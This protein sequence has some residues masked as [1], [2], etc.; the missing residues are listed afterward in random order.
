MRITNACNNRC[1][2]CLDRDTLDGS[3]RAFEEIEADLETGLKNGAARAII[4][5]GEPTIH[6]LFPEI[7]AAASKMGYR[8][9]QAITNGRM[10]YYTDFARKSAQAGLREIT[11]SVH[12]HTP[13]LFERLTRVPGSFQQTLLG[14]RN[15]LSTPGLVV[16]ADIVVFGGINAPFLKDIVK[17]YYAI[18]VREFDLLYP[19]P[20]G[21]AWENREE[22]LSGP[23][24]AAS[25]VASVLPLAESHEIT[26]WTNRFPAGALEGHEKFIQSPEKIRDEMSGRSGMFSAFL[27]NGVQPPCMAERCEFCNMEDFCRMLVS[28]R[29]AAADGRKRIFEVNGE[30]ISSLDAVEADSISGL[31]L[32]PPSL[33]EH[34]SARRI[35]SDETVKAIYLYREIPDKFDTGAFPNEEVEISLNNRTAPALLARG[36]PVQP[37]APVRITLQNYASSGECEKDTVSIRVFFK[38]L[39]IPSSVLGDSVR[40]VPPC[41]SRTGTFLPLDWTP[42][43]LFSPG[44][45]WD[46][47]ALTDYFIK[48]RFYKKSF[49]CAGCRFFAQCP[50]LHI[51][52]IRTFGFSE[53]AGP[54]ECKA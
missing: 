50:G 19:V 42:P 10:F 30:N 36:I 17:F 2:F 16:S 35:L 14:L 6:P 49:R 27:E 4:S 22:M 48:N 7:I 45:K 25:A 46:L 9:V 31:V 32:D 54:L 37:G 12:G 11:F 40:N 26:F 29:Q 52:Y 43:G 34:P 28:E 23:E 13:E 20:F 21:N 15:A 51:N 53:I 41:V 3:V 47:A 33:R 18:G 1:A 38:H 5:G 39:E 8:W 24:T 44:K